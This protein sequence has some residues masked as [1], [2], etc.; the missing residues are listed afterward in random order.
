[1]I[2]T[3]VTSFKISFAQNA[4]TS[5]YFL[6]RVPFI[7]KKVPETLYKEVSLKLVFGTI[8]QV[9]SLLISFFYKSL[10]LGFIILLPSVLIG[11]DIIEPASVFLHILFFLSFVLGALM[12]STV[13]TPDKLAFDM[14]ILMRTDAREYYISQIV[15]NRIEGAVQLIL[16]L[17]IARLIIGFSPFE[18]FVLLIEL[19]TFRLIG[20]WFHLYVYDKTGRIFIKNGYII[21]ALV[22]AGIILAYGLP[23]AGYV[24][25]LRPILLNIFSVV[26]LLLLG[27]ATLVYLW[28]YR[29]YNLIAKA[30]LTK[31]II[32]DVDTILSEITFVDVKLDEERL[33]KEEI[34]IELFQEKHGYDYLNSL[35]FLRHRRILISPIKTRVIIIS[36]VFVII[37]LIQLFLPESKPIIFES[38]KGSSTT[39]VIIM[40]LLST[41][42]RITKAMFYNCDVSLLRYSFYRERMNILSN[43]ALRLKKVVFLNIIPALAII[44]LLIIL[45]ITSGFSSDLISLVPLFLSILSLACFFSIHHLFM[46]YAIQPYTAQLK[47]KSPLF[48]FINMVVWLLSYISLQIK[49]TSIYF[50]I[51]VLII[52]VLYIATAMI[53]TYRVAPRTFR[54]K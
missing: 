12:D 25:Y 32:F 49:T 7:G 15:Y 6:Q 31:D 36:A 35:F 37:L 23:I 41:G 11:R 27:I 45:V 18:A 30:L 33:F 43:F 34:D 40:Y 47:I 46:Y 21:G 26:I 51:G 13:L 53:I 17:I 38:I 50:T 5:I 3:F 10:Y 22:I 48:K 19:A 24:I 54:L 44:L 39:M 1:M 16:P 4:N 42:E 29:N 52:T 28:K 2:R 20:E 14:I 8:S 9:L